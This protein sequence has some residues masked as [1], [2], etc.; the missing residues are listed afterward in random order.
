MSIVE[1]LVQVR[2]ALLDSNVVAYNTVSIKK[3]LE[4]WERVGGECWGKKRSKKRSRG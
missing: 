3:A 1:V 2:Q 4:G